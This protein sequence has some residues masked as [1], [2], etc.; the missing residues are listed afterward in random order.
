MKQGKPRQPRRTT[1]NKNKK[2]QAAKQKTLSQDDLLDELPD[3]PTTKI[4]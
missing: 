2:V 1:S 3:V 4:D